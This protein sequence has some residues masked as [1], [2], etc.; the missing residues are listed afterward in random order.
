MPNN[1]DFTSQITAFRSAVYG[2]EVRQA[3]I[4]IAEAL[5]T[6]CNNQLIS[7]D[8][9]LSTSGAG[10]DAATVGS[11]LSTLDTLAA[12]V[13]N[14]SYI[15]YNLAVMARGDLPD[16]KDG[17]SYTPD[18]D[19][20]AEPGIWSVSA[21]L[22]ASLNST[23]SFPVTTQ[24]TFGVFSAT[25]YRNNQDESL[26][27][28]YNTGGLQLVWT[29]SNV[30]WRAHD[31]VSGSSGTWSAW[32]K[33]Y[34]EVD[35]TL[36]QSG[37]AADAA[38]VGNEITDLKSA[39][40]NKYGDYQVLMNYGSANSSTGVITLN[41]NTKK[42]L[43]SNIE[44]K[45]LYKY[46][47]C[48][49]AEIRFMALYYASD[50]SFVKATDWISNSYELE[51]Y[52]FVAILAKNGSAG[53]ATFA[54]TEIPVYLS[55][56][57]S[58]P[59]VETLS[60]SV[61]TLSGSVETLSGSVETDE[62][63]A[64]NLLYDDVNYI[65]RGA[66]VASS[67][68][69][70]TRRWF[71]NLEI[72]AGSY[73]KSFN[74]YLDLKRIAT[75]LTVEVW[76]LAGGTLTKVKSVTVSDFTD[77]SENVVP[78]DYYCASPVMISFLSNSSVKYIA[79]GGVHILNSSDTSTSTTTL[80]FSSL[81]D[82]GD[83]APSVTVETVKAKASGADAFS[84]NVITV[85][86]GMDYEEIQSALNA[87]T[88]DSASK[89]YTILLMPRGTPYERFSTLRQFSQSYPW[90]SISPRYISIIG[91]DKNHCI[92]KSD[93]GN[94]KLPCGEPMLNGA[95]K[96]ITFV[97]TNSDQDPNATQGGYC[98]H[99]DCRTLDDVGYNM[100]IEDCDFEDASGPCLGIGMHK[101]CTLTIRRCN[102]KTTL[103]ANYN[104]HE[105][106]T[107]LVNYGVIFCHSSTRADA[108]DQN[109]I[110]ED[111]VGLC[112]EGN[113][114]LWLEVAGDY[115]PSTASF[116]YRLIRNVFWNATE[117][118]PSYSISS[119]LTADPMNYGNNIP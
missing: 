91:V 66:T 52:P 102:F 7:V 64:N 17:V 96:N 13:N 89:P 19:T 94:Y 38:V 115:D 63:L 23:Y 28:A 103:S 113:K 100:L 45:G 105:G 55:Q 81:S 57:S 18:I 48:T 71:L 84:E 25:A 59:S 21:S 50:L 3:L 95:I 86:P 1:V 46:I 112:E 99:I 14:R 39:L 82:F 114:G 10:A 34:L 101:N 36:T 58:V 80:S 97:M 65:N 78:I 29:P 117:N 5:E 75:T 31:Y 69:T 56:I 8:S 54:S 62:E 22:A 37:Q 49:N 87:I 70:S 118:A 79:N 27:Y 72:P 41:P 40:S 73:I 9:T 74:Y 30:Y 107:N 11:R 108:T 60:G 44:K 43:V 116:Y 83:Y 92:I 119:T 47:V 16:T 24:C 76:T 110:I 88:D 15:P 104:P 6:A 77:D 98:L 53:T 2:R 42:R 33:L 109:I 61:E 111:C 51:D 20:W 68:Y 93:S 35:T 67:S 12:S 90:N 26:S 106:Y 4:D 85:G 32:R